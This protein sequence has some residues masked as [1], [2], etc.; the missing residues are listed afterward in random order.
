MGGLGVGLSP[1]ERR[2]DV[3]RVARVQ[4][5]RLVVHRH[6]VAQIRAPQQHPGQFGIAAAQL[7]DEA[8]D[9]EAGSHGEFLGVRAYG[10]PGS[11]EVAHTDVDQTRCVGSHLSRRSRSSTAAAGRN[12]GR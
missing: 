10:G 3:D 1:G 12:S 4:G 2:Q 8:A 5:L 7:I 6:P 9:R 11:R